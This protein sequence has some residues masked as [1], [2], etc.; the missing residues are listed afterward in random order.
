MHLIRNKQNKVDLK[1][2]LEVIPAQE[3]QYC[4]VRQVAL[5]VQTALEVQQSRGLLSVLHGPENNKQQQTSMSKS[6][7]S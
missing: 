4:Q 7:Q 1:S 2:K 3:D 6:E 5:E